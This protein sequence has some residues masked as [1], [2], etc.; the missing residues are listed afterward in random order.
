MNRISKSLVFATASAVVTLLP[1]LAMAGQITWWTPNWGEQRARK[2]AADFEKAN[3][4]ITINI[5]VTTSQG[6][7][8]RVLTALQS[9]AAPD[10]IEVQHAWVQGYAQS[11]LV[12]PVDDLMKDTSDYNKAALNYVTYQDHLYGV[13][14]RVE[15]IGLL[16]N[17]DDFTKAGLDPDKPPQTWDD[18]TADAK[19]L[20][21]DGVFGMAITAGG[22]V[23]NT[24][25]RALP[26]I[27]MNGGDI[28]SADGKTATINTPQAVAAV[29]YYT[30]FFTNGYSP[31]STLQND[32]VANRQLFIAGKVAMYQSGQFDIAPIQQGAPSL[33]LGAAPLPHPTG[34]SSAC[35]LSGWSYVIPKDAKNPTDAKKFIAFLNTTDN[36]AYFTDTFPARVSSLQAQRFQDPLLKPFGAAL[37][38]GRPAPNNPHWVQISQAFF[39]GIQ[40]ILTKQQ[41]VQTAMNQTN[42]DIQSLLDQ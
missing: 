2:L 11:D 42:D 10:I 30:D 4:D 28:I 36:D 15:C 25:T 26:L 7:P 32:G 39:D 29:K 17:R 18:W 27:W 38:D 1:T 35:I 24:I 20:T 6:L 33:K 16:Y 21:R 31:D 34:K 41:D 14:Y 5:E 13:P 12:Q 40:R 8:E 9:G 23:G 22:E 37:A 19:A 3:P